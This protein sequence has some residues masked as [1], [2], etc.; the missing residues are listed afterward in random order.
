SKIAASVA[1]FVVAEA[2]LAIRGIHRLHHQLRNGGE[3]LD[4]RAAVPHRL[5]GARTVGIVV[6]GYVGRA[7][8]R[9]LVPFG[10]RVL[11]VDQFLS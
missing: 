2:L 3:W 10:C 5:L 1:E 11:V 9:L 4:V 7:V 6:A 8:M